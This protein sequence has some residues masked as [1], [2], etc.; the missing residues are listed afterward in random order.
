L[1]SNSAINIAIA[2]I[3]CDEQ[4]LGFNKKSINIE[5]EIDQGSQTLTKDEI[6]NV[7]VAG[8]IKNLQLIGGVLRDGKTEN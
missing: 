3:F 2:D 8:V 4:R 1:P 7:I 5:F 6:D